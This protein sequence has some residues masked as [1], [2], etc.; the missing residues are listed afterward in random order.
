M[1]IASVPHTGTHFI[2]ELITSSGVKIDQKHFASHEIDYN[3]LI[4]SPIRD[5]HDCYVT[6]KSRG[7]LD[8]TFFY[9]WF[10]FNRVYESNADLMVIPIDQVDNREI[11]LSQLSKKLGIP[12]TTD[13]QPVS[14]KDREDI[15]RGSVNLRYLYNLPV[16]KDFG[17]IL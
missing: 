6:H 12:L 9:S 7:H 15:T 1:I 11:Y 5:P 2:K 8:E 14:S 10:E 3:Q 17:Y 13:W 4:I 16:V